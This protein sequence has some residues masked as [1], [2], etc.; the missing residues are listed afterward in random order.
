M[1][2]S[3]TDIKKK[4]SELEELLR[5]HNEKYYN[6]DDPEIT[7]HEYDEL[8]LKLRA[9]EKEYP[10]Y[11]SEDSPVRHVGGSAKREAGAVIRHRVP[12]LSI[13]DVFSEEEV[14]GW[15][16]GMRS[17]LG[18]SAE[19]LVET[20]IDGLSMALRY[21]NGRLVTA[22]TRGD[23]RQ[24][25]EDVTDNAKVID[26]VVLFIDDAPEYLELRGEVYMENASFDRI[27][28][29][30]EAA[31]K[32]LFANPRNCAAGTLRQL[33]SSIVKERELSLFIFNLQ[34]ARGISFER[35]DEMYEYLKSKGIKTIEKYYRCRTEDEVWD[36]ITKIGQMRGSLDYDIDGAVVKLNILSDRE[37]CEDTAKNAG[38]MV[39]YKYPPEEKET[40]LR[41]VEIS[42]GRTGRLTPTAIF[43]PIRLC[44]TTVSRATLHNQDYIDGLDVC[45]GDTIVVYK[46]G[47]II[48]KVKAVVREKRPNDAVRFMIPDVCPVCGS[49]VVRE[50]D[51]ADMKC[52]GL[53]CPAQIERHIINFASR[54]AMDIKGLG[55]KIIKK[56]IDE[57]FVKNAADIYGLH[58]HREE[59]IDK[60]IVGRQKATDNLLDAIEASKENQPD[61]LLTGL[62]IPN[63]G[64]TAAKSV[65]KKF[66][67]IDALMDATEKDLEAVEGVGTI[68]A[69]AIHAFFASEQNRQII[70][71][72]K[73]A[74]VNMRM[75]DRRRRPRLSSEG[76]GYSA[77]GAGLDVKDSGLDAE[78]AGLGAKGFGL[79]AAGAGLDV[80]DSGLDA[81]G[82]GLGAKGFGLDAAG[83]GLDV[84]DSGLDAEGAGLGAKGFGLDA[85][86]AGLDVKDSG[87]DAAGAGLGAKGF[88]LDAA[89]AGL[90]SADNVQNFLDIDDDLYDIFSGLTF[91]ITGTLPTMG[92]KEASEYI[93]DR[94]GKVAGSVSKKTDYLVA[95]EAAG[96]KLAKARS[97]GTRIISEEEL[98]MLGNGGLRE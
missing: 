1:S 31:G 82:A 18:E 54:S 47:E 19:F 68:T 25:G 35:H 27:N 55:E 48:P 51:T 76:T 29:I 88:G 91:V 12:M 86:G 52:T 21:E 64:K 32:K 42:V 58:M 11:S 53:S 6:Q 13:Q 50:S 5:Y 23:G 8:S 33:D 4:M 7:D 97:L 49:K 9:L 81:E 95:G 84:K 62:G 70:G 75:A 34:D 79:D 72:L 77:A 71:R 10:Q 37:K 94:G 67:S 61:Q 93:E 83:A 40:I 36:A 30:Q 20:K 17:K 16:E 26:D 45:I 56:L 90:G 39:A 24:F 38:F 65:M 96:S 57:G 14:R 92:R 98:I 74:G 66:M 60:K 73:D 87:L 46:S 59:L 41:D 44:G 22:V 3:S 2:N 85:A 80:K 63:T 89:G 15:V 78:G 69:G 28:E 43:E